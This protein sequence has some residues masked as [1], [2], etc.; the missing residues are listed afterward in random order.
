MEEEL[1]NN[2]L[3]EL[4][5]L[6]DTR[7]PLVYMLSP[8]IAGKISKDGSYTKRL[9]DTF[10]NISEDIFKPI[11]KQRNKSLLMLGTPTEMFN[12]V[13]EYIITAK[14]AN[15]SLGVSRNL[16]VYINIYPYKLT[17]IEQSNIVS[18]F[19]NSVDNTIAVKI[20][21]MNIP[22]LTPAWV[23]DNVGYLIMYNGL[24]WL[25]YHISMQT[26]VN[27]PLLE[28]SLLVPTIV[29]YTTPDRDITKDL[30]ESMM[31][32]TSTVI[33]LGMINNKYF[34]QIVRKKNS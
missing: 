26:L 21:S 20:V 33:R 8:T 15:D 11:Y 22:E 23:E 30:L 24:D 19:K 4:D 17:V 9:K 7:L 25:E 28:V 12:L 2:I 6:F 16:T 32:Y 5:S 31:R 1:N 14:Y 13:K 3:V 27:K 10:G 34:S 29:A 18:S